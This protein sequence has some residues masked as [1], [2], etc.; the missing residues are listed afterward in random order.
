MHIKMSRMQ[1]RVKYICPSGT[2]MVVFSF[3][4]R[5]YVIR[6]IVTGGNSSLQ[7]AENRSSV[8]INSKLY[9]VHSIDLAQL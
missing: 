5:N 9:S 6:D 2:I 3:F 4:C 8:L 1:F 7:E